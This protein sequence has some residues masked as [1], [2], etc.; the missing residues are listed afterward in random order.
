MEMDESLEEAA[1]R[2]LLEETS[3]RAG[4]LLRFDT[5]DKPGRDPRG[6][7]ITQVF[8]K[9]DRLWQ[10]VMPDPLPGMNLAHSLSLLLITPRL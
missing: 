8:V 10:V 1:R 3:V 2:E 6:R 4:E 5:Y 7:T 9:W